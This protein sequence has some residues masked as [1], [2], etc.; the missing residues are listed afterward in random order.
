MSFNSLPRT[1]L[2]VGLLAFGANSL[3]LVLIDIGL[4][5]A[6]AAFFAAL[7]IGLAALVI[8]WRFNVPRM[9]SVVPPIIIMIPGLYAFEMVV[10]FNLGQVVEALRAGA[11]CGFVIGAL[12]IGLATARLFGR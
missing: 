5:P 12:A 11:V 10:L 4:M 6:L 9:A 1:V 8:E 3:R 7:A 2:A